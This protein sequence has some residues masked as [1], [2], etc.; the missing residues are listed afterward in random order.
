MPSENNLVKKHLYD[1][2]LERDSLIIPDLGKFEA[3]YTGA[4]LEPATN[5]VLPPNKQIYFDPSVKYDD[6]VL[7]RYLAQ[8]ENVSIE[9]AQH[10]I[11][12][13]VTEVK[14]DLGSRRPYHL[15]HFGT[16][17]WSPE[18]NIEFAPNEDLNYHGDSFGLPDL[19]NLKVAT[20]LHEESIYKNNHANHR[21]NTTE[22]EQ[23]VAE[24]ERLENEDVAVEE[25]I[26]D[27]SSRRWFTVVT[28]VLLLVSAITAYFL[29][30]DQNPLYWIGGG[31]ALTHEEETTDTEENAIPGEETE[32][33]SWANRDMSPARHADSM[34]INCNRIRLR[35]FQRLPRK[36]PPGKTGH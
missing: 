10:S 27:H 21:F 24:D 12:Y 13:F 29:V 11:K 3:D 36:P 16:L 9:E 30:T 28:I 23:P 31:G 20:T 8:Q 26:V 14:A 7:A 33:S 6:G 34:R 19:Y 25:E 5:K 32:G 4:K 15:D 2:F 17:N 35:F 22:P 18:G 1:W